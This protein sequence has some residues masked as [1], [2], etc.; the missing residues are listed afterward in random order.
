M[1]YMIMGKF[2]YMH[3]CCMIW[4]SDYESFGEYED[5]VKYYGF[6]LVVW[7]V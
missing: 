4:A 7:K 6:G 1:K 3:G 2:S 5:L